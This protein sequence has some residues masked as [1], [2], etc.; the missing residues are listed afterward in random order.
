VVGAAS[1]GDRRPR[2][3]SLLALARD[4]DVLV[5]CAR[6]DASNRHMINKAVIE[7]LGP[8]GLLVNV[9]RGSL[10][11]E[12]ALIAAL[13]DGRWAWPGWTCSTTSRP[14]PRAGP[15]CRTPC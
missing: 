8:Q 14:R 10:I 5:V 2:A 1:Q 13:K 9:A 4:S 7:A 15:A 12:D 11:D 3:K 6:P